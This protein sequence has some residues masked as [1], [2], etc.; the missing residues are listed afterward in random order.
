MG[1]VLFICLRPCYIAERLQGGYACE[2]IMWTNLSRYFCS[3]VGHARP[4]YYYLLNI[5]WGFF[6]WSIYL[7]GAFILAFSARSKNDKV[8]VRLL[9]VWIFS[10][11]LFFSFSKGKRPQY[12][13]SM[14][15]ALA[16]LVGYL[17]DR[18]VFLW[19]DKF[20][21]RSI[22]VPSVVAMVGMLILGVALPV[23][24]HARYKAFFE[25]ALALGAL[26]VV[27]SGLFWFAWRKNQAR[28]LVFLPVAF[29]IV[30]MVY[31]VHVLIPKL[32]EYK[33]PRQFCD[34]I[35]AHVEEGA[36][37]AMYQFYRAIYVYYTDSFAKVIETEQELDE[38]IDRPKRTVVAMREDVY[39]NLKDSIKEKTAVIRREKIGH[40]PMILISN[41]R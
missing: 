28:R 22:S 19:E 21:R 2:L 8:A 34:T 16:L 24:V 41:K 32:E 37:W 13:L 23:L 30:F 25:P 35:V 14:Y 29:I 15:P 31:A 18:A 7:P 36:D 5:P 12:V 6:P 17:G 26:L 39:E 1:L 38:F 9:L 20:Y 27:F 4:V 11:L 40:R 33:S 3:G 10:L